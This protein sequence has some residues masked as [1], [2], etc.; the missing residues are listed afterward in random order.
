V[1]SIR[2]ADHPRYRKY[3]EA[4]IIL[5]YY[6]LFYFGDRSLTLE[7]RRKGGGHGGGG[8]AAPMGVPREGGVIAARPVA[9]DDV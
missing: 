4:S 1:G 9:L 5:F 2:T 8:G 6:V 7:H 3:A